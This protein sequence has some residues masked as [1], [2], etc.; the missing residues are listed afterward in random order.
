[1]KHADSIIIENDVIYKL[2][3]NWSGS[4]L[5]KVELLLH[6]FGEPIHIKYVS[7]RPPS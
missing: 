1:M 5:I 6:R 7:R 4:L 2:S 3:S